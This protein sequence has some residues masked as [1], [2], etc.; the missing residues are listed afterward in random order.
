MAREMGGG[1]G[2]CKAR[3]AKSSATRL[4]ELRAGREGQRDSWLGC[5][6]ARL[7]SKGQPGEEP[8]WALVG[9]GARPFVVNP[10]VKVEW[11]K[12]AIN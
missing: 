12:S 1:G 5:R 2:R 7:S 8:L 9:P 4:K 3:E 10:T 11:L 6:S